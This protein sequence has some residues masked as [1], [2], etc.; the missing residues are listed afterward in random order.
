M[1]RDSRQR[2]LGILG[3]SRGCRRSFITSSNICA[4]LFLR[5]LLALGDVSLLL[6]ALGDSC[7]YLLFFRVEGVPALVLDVPALAACRANGDGLLVDWIS[8]SVPLGSR[9][10]A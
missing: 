6:F 2:I 10:L 3:G 7:I 8:A 1:K 9:L 5:R 4:S